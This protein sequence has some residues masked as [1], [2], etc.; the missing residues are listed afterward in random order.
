[1]F[2][3]GQE[4]FDHQDSRTAAVVARLL[5]LD[6]DEVGSALDQIVMRF[7]GRHRDLLGT[8]ERHAA[9]VNDRLEPGSELSDARNRIRHPHARFDR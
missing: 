5:A 1:M 3:P 9:A 8:F 7:G 6:D 2:V 4:G